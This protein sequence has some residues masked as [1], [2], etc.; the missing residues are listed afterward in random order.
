ME[1]TNWKVEGMT[2]SNCSLTVTKYLEKKGKRNVKVNLISGDVVFENDDEKDLDSVIEGI[3]GLGYKVNTLTNTSRQPKKRLL[4]NHFQRFI[5][6]AIFTLPL[7]LHMFDRWLHI[8][9]LMNPWVQL[10][11][12]LP[13]YIVGMDFFGRSAIKSI[14]NG[15]PNMNVLIAIGATAAFVYS[16]AG[17]LFNLGGGY[18][19][20]ETAAAILTLVFL[21]NYLEDASIQSTQRELNKLAKSQKVMANMIAFDD[22][23]EEIIFPVENDQ[24]KSGDLILIKSGEQV[25]A[26]CKILT[27]NASVN[28]SIITGESLPVDKNPKDKLIGGSIVTDGTIKAQVTAAAKDSVL[29]NII[30]LVKQAQ[31][32]KPPIQQVADRISAIF[33]P[34]VLGIA[35][36]TFVVNIIILKEFTPS[37]MRSI[38]VLVIACPCAMGLATPAAIAVGLGRAARNGVLFRNA[39]SLEL[40]KDIKQVVFDKTGTLTTGNFSIDNFKTNL[41]EDEFKKIVYSLEKYSNHPLAASVTRHWKTRDEIR[42]A[43]TVE[44]KGVGMKGVTK[45]GDRYEAGSFKIAANVTDDRS[46]TIYVLKNDQLAGWIDLKDEVRPEAAGIVNYLRQRGIKTFLLSGDRREATQHIAQQLGI[47]EFVAEQSP[48][49]KLDKIGELTSSA[50]TAMIGDG[51]NDA[52]AL[53]K[54]TIGVSLS[55]AS[56]VAMQTADVVLMS[57]GLNHLPLSLGLGKHTYV[58]IRQ[59]LF[60]A[61]FYNIIAIPVAAFGF[62]TPAFGALVMG[63]SDVVLA[64]NSGRLFVKKVV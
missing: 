23:H 21:G 35:V 50:P 15:M 14:S 20:Y 3:E 47:D 5:F 52:P 48:Q 9:W 34:V 11:L 33:V 54:A 51:I 1:K 30:D 18:L 45:E 60:W 25:P 29:A 59:N 58:T 57:S 62:L 32:E 64:I 28:E 26:D 41:A 46:H 42:W 61:F 63:L 4:S 22:K 27:G 53:A 13:V 36:V 43:S 12:C 31:G 37:L 39:K 38:A 7:M 16:L 8:E 17:T 6:C 24:L 40:F 44:V 56:Q 19:F 2:C 10:A 49:Q 55:E